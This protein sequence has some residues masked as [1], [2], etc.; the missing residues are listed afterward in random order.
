MQ[1]TPNFYLSEF[2]DSVQGARAGIFNTPDPFVIKNLFAL[3]NL[4]EAVRKLLGDKVIVISSGYRSQALNTLVKGAKNSDHMTGEAVDFVCNG[5]GTPLQVATKIAGSN[6]KWG[7]LIHEGTWVHLSLP[8][9]AHKQ[10]V[11]TAVFTPGKKT[12]YTKGL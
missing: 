10:E 9:E 7:Q 12:T 11:L 4:M 2:T 6:L 8:S 5:F 3:A 1:L